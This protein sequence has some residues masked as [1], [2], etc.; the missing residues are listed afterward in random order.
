VSNILT[1]KIRTKICRAHHKMILGVEK[2]KQTTHENIKQM[3]ISLGG[4]I[5]GEKARI[6]TI[7]HPVLVIG[8]GGTGTDALVAFEISN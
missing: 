4:G 7:N 5:F 8:L 2:M 6:D 3:D 1:K